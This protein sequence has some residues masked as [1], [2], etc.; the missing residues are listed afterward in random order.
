MTQKQPIKTVELDFYSHLTVRELEAK[1]AELEKQDATVK[2]GKEMRVLKT[3]LRERL[4]VVKGRVMSFEEGNTH[5]LLFYDSTG[6]FRKMAGNSV[7]FYSLKIVE[8]IGRRCKVMP[9]KDRYARSEDGIVSIKSYAD[10]DEKLALLGIVPDTELSREELHFYKLPRVYTDEQI[11]KLRD[12]AGQDLEKIQEIILPQSPL[13]DLYRALLE[14]NQM[15]YHNTRNITDAYARRVYGETLAAEADLALR[16]YLGMANVRVQTTWAKAEVQR[17][18]AQVN[19]LVR[20]SAD[21]VAGQNLMN[22]LI[23]VAQMKGR[24]SNIEN[25]R[26]LHH[27]QI[28]RIL[29]KLILIER[30]AEREYGKILREE[31]VGK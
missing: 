24:M 2:N 17:N 25:L 29:T 3:A 26:L 18:L 4:H 14:L 11:E 6:G 30:M 8:R 7:L 10:L 27:K 5:H 28:G 13:P 12:L 31:R 16:S 22:L 15:V 20:A 9:D 19:S 21:K 23:S 1:I